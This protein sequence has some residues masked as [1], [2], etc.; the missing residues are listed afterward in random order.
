MIKKGESFDRDGA[1]DSEKLN[2][3]NETFDVPLVLS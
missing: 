2:F 1:R 3:E